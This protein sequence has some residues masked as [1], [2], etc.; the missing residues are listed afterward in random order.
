MKKTLLLFILG[1]FFSF[2]TASGDF[3]KGYLDEM[4]D[5]DYFVIYAETDTLEV[6]F[7]YPSG[8]EFWVLVLGETGIELGY[9]DL[10][11]GDNIILLTGGGYFTLVIISYGGDDKWTAWWED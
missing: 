2:T 6:E 3:L 5:S 11:G 9:F 1:I 4:G 10:A 7:D 8:A